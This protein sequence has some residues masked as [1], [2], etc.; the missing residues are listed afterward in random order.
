M[1]YSL[2]GRDIHQLVK[3][4]PTEPWDHYAWRIHERDNLYWWVPV[5]NTRPTA[6][7]LYD[8]SSDKVIRSFQYDQLQ[9]DAFP[10]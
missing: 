8:L 5:A 10:A 7:R 2:I 4:K 1:T 3:I 9:P 6:L